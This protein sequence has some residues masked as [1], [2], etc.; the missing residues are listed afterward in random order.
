MSRCKLTLFDSV[1]GEV[2]WKI[3][4]KDICLHAR[5]PAE[6][7]YIYR[8]FLCGDNGMRLPLG[9]MLRKGEEFVLEKS[10]ST[11]KY[12]RVFS[13][14]R[15]CRG[16]IFRAR[17]GERVMAP[18]HFAYSALRPAIGDEITKDV[19][20]QQCIVAQADT[21]YIADY[22]MTYLLFPF[23]EGGNS[24][25]APFFFLTTVLQT[26]QGRFGVLCIDAQGMPKKLQYSGTP[27]I[28]R[29][30]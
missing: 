10:L 17:P 21:L 4:Q 22:T 16:E 18:L 26:P 20:L 28:D 19:L 11:A 9:V 12:G 15:A 3:D 30:L 8:L 14:E 27:G 6:E 7:G 5:C 13:A 24:S 25:F 1:I 23:A 2:D 29:F